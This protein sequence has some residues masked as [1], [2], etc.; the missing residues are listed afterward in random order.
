MFH[1]LFLLTVLRESG[2]FQLFGRH[3]ACISAVVDG[4]SNEKTKEYLNIRNY[5]Y[6]IKGE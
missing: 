2:I 5:T 4:I 1:G 3:S 6:R